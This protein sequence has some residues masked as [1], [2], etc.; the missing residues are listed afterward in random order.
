MKTT[1]TTWTERI[2]S[3]AT[4]L[5]LLGG[6]L[7]G[8]LFLIAFVLGGASGEALAVATRKEILPW[9]IR[10]ATVGMLAGLVGFYSTGIHSL[11]MEETGPKKE[12]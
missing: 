3:V 2:F 6:G 8:L 7:V 10:I 1:V 4:L 9:I 11:K 12:R 5:A